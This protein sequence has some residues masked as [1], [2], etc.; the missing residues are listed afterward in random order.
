MKAGREYGFG[1]D[2]CPYCQSSDLV[3]LEGEAGGHGKKC[4]NC[5]KRW[6]ISKMWGETLTEVER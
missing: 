6:A 2:V 4:K 1:Y 5:G 3:N